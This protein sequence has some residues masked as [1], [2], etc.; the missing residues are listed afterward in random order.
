MENREYF[1][2]RAQ[3]ERNAAAKARDNAVCRIHMTLAKE[4]DFRA[5]CEPVQDE[6]FLGRISR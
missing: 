5:A 1:K 2:S 6:P 4:Y 3:A